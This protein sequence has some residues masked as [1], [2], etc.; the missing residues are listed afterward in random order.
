MKKVKGTIPVFDICSLNGD[1]HRYTDIQVERFAAY[2]EKHPNLHHVHGHTFYHIVVFTAGAGTYTIDFEQYPVNKGEA[3]FMLPGQVHGW[4]FEGEVDGYVINFSEEFLL[5]F[6]ADKEYLNRFSFLSDT[7]NNVYSISEEGLR[8]ITQQLTIATNELENA[9]PYQMDMVRTLLLSVMIH[10]ERS[11]QKDAT[12][13][14]VKNTNIV[15]L[16]NFKKLINKY[17]TQYKLPKEYASMLYITPNHLNALC[18]DLLGRSA[19]DM[20]RDR[21][22]LEAKRQLVNIDNNVASIAYGLG[23]TDNSYFTKFFKKYTGVTPEEFKKKQSL[24]K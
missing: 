11:I 7:S 13:N 9:Q 17:Y 6:L 22:L 10:F 23:F 21:V 15:L 8:V 24:P 14:D 19:G 1:D 20:I 2:L 18:Q 4:N 5:S 16:N 12:T 3:Y